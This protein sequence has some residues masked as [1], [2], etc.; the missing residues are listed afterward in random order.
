ME[1]RQFRVWWSANRQRFE[2]AAKTEIENLKAQNA[3]AAK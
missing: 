1:L 3:E 2:P